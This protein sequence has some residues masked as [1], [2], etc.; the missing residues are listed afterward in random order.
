MEQLQ[1][2][3]W[4]AEQQLSDRH[5]QM[6]NPATV[7]ECISDLRNLLSGNSLSQTKSFIRSFI[8]EVKVTGKEVLLT[9]TLPLL[10]KGMTEEKVPVLSIVHDGGPNNTFAKPIDTFFEL[11]INSAPSPF[12]EQHFEKR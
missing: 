4:E 9:Y 7:A 11:S 6:A 2:A 10:P 12:G 3:K 1:A 8:K 5:I